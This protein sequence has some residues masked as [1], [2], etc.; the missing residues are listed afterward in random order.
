MPTADPPADVDLTLRASAK[1]PICGV[2]QPHG[3]S[4]RDVSLY[5]NSLVAAWGYRARA[6]PLVVGPDSEDHL[7][8]SVRRAVEETEEQGRNFV[9]AYGWIHDDYVNVRDV[10]L[11]LFEDIEN[12]RGEREQWAR[13]NTWV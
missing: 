1:C 8:S 11:M 2:D 10:L 6:F 7:V 13:P 12:L 4:V 5:L 3:H 9:R